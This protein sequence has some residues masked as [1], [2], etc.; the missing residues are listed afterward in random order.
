MATPPK[1]QK[2]S[3]LHRLLVI[4]PHVKTRTVKTGQGR[5]GAQIRIQTPKSSTM[6]GARSSMCTQH[7]SVCGRR[8]TATAPSFEV[9]AVH[10]S[11]NIVYVLQGQ[12]RTLPL[13]VCICPRHAPSAARDHAGPG[14]SQK[15]FELPSCG[16]RPLLGPPQKGCGS[17]DQGRAQQPIQGP[18]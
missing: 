17:V 11:H 12:Y 14:P 8:V 5:A 10:H 9:Y 15:L 16:P 7:G 2:G 18:R 13:G 4:S 1:S 6:V 3:R